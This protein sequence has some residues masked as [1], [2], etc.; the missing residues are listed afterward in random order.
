M[1]AAQGGNKE[2][3][4]L[5]LAKENIDVNIQTI[6][7]WIISQNSNLFFFLNEALHFNHLWNLSQIFNITSLMLAAQNDNADAVQ[8]LLAHEG[9]DA[10]IQDI[11]NI[12]TFMK[13]KSI[14][15]FKWYSTF[16]IFL[17]FK[18]NI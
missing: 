7:I 5:L 10:N 15:F 17:E 1:F 8:L 12:K 16:Q 18:S 14:F 6:W 4:R 2:I 3:V 11:W 9:I 13:F